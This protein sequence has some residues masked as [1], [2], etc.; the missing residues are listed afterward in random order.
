MTPRSGTLTTA[1]ILDARIAGSFRHRFWQELL[2]NSAQFPIANLLLEVL[3][4]GWGIVLAPDL[5]ALAAAAAVQAWVLTRVGERHPVYRF[6]GNLVGPA[7]YTVVEASLE[8][9]A[10]FAAPNHV[11]YWCFGLALGLVQFGESIAAAR[12]A[13]L[14]TVLEQVVRA[15]ILFVVYVLF[16]VLT[17]ER[18]FSWREFAADRSHVFI[19][20]ATLILGITSGLEARAARAYLSLLRGTSTQLKRYSEWLLGAD[21]LQRVIRDPQALSLARRDRSVLFMDIRGFT[22]WSERCPPEVVVQALNAYYGA[23]EPILRGH[24][25]IKLKFSADEVLAVFE[26]PSQALASATALRDAA[27]AALSGWNLLAG[28]GL[29]VGAVVEGVLGSEGVK[30]YDV[31]GDTVNTAKRIESAAAGGEVLVSAPLL[32]RVEGPVAV[33]PRR[34]VVAKGKQAPLQVYPVLMGACRARPG[35]L[36]R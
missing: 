4:E 24:G 32:Q 14:L 13:A 23:A 25:A 2:R 36:P 35:Q 1:S 27:H 22:G 17:S 29:H 20:L 16:E 26:T 19:A 33:G 31:I 28:I 6:A 30:T 21:L 10:F 7:S 5:Y 9:A 11:A 18:P 8:G 3:M 12:V 15:S 34:D